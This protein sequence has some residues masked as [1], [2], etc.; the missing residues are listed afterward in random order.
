MNIPTLNQPSYKIISSFAKTN[1][2]N[3]LVLINLGSTTTIKVISKWEV[4]ATGSINSNP[5]EC[6]SIYSVKK[7]SKKIYALIKGYNYTGKVSLT[8]KSGITSYSI[9]ITE[10]DCFNVCSLYYGQNF[11]SLTSVSNFCKTETIVAEIKESDKYGK[12]IEANSSSNRTGTFYSLADLN[13]PKTG[14]YILEFDLAIG[15]TNT[16]TTNSTFC[17]LT[18]Q[19]NTD[20]YLLKMDSCSYNNG[21]NDLTWY[22]NNTD[23][24][25]KFASDF[26]HFK[27][28]VDRINGKIGLSIYTLDDK[29][30]L[31]KQIINKSSSA[32]SD[33]VNC[34]Y[35]VL[36]R[37]V[38]GTI[39]LNNS[40]FIHMKKHKLHLLLLKE[41]GIY[42][43]VQ[44]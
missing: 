32:K 36:S 37:G 11:E 26:V 3:S 35:M 44:F 38:R 31:E 20:S 16:T 4:I 9:T 22:I 24:Q 13:I 41:K 43:L 14:S 17:I 10:D 12:Y 42:P 30:I 6:K 7:G 23:T 2:G 39:K 40:Q 18:D 29:V 8:L 34:F 33:I 5:V 27:L 19:S 21:N 25:V 15:N 1:P 28:I